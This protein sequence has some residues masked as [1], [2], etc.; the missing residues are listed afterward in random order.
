MVTLAR[1]RTDTASLLEDKGQAR[2][3]ECEIRTD[4]KIVNLRRS[5]NPVLVLRRVLLIWRL[6]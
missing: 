5:C 3:N 2:G 4:I 1:Y 6:W